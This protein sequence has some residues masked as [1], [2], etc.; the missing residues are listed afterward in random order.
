MELTAVSHLAG[1]ATSAPVTELG[2]SRS[3][4]AERLGRRSITDT[5]ILGQSNLLDLAGLGVLHLGG[6]GDDL[7]IEPPSLL[8]LLSAAV[9]LGGILVLNL[10]ADVEVRSDVLGCLTHGLQ[11]VGR[12]LVLQDFLAER[13]DCITAGRHQLSTKGDT[14]IDLTQCNLVGDVLNS[15]ETGGTESVDGRC[16]GCVGDAGRKGGGTEEIGG[17]AVVDLYVVSMNPLLG[18]DRKTYITQA[19]ILD[20]SRVNLRLVDNLLQQGVY[21][22]IQLCVLESTLNGLGQR[23]TQS[24]R[25]DYIVWVLLGAAQV[26]I[27]LPCD[28]DGNPTWRQGQCFL[29]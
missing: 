10:T 15:L 18:R 3:D 8:G 5:L 14:D 7:I 13:L 19:D 17:L 26:S 24:E 25:N 23:S 21:D 4:L 28:A 16:A 29:P 2:E 9:R 22:V 6:D 27:L 20:Q 1:V 12:L 11:A